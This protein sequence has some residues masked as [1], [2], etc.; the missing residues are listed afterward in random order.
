MRI[1]H[2]SDWHI[3]KRL[4]G[5][6]RLA[7]QADALDEIAALCAKEQIDVVLVAGDV[8]DTYLPSAEAEDL[9]YEKIKKIAGDTRAVVV[10]SGNHDD[11]VRLSAATPLCEPQGIY[12]YGNYGY[13]PKRGGNRPV[14]IADSGPNHIVLEKGGDKIF[15]NILPY[16]N[17]TRL[18]ED[19]NPDETFL[20]KMSRWMQSGQAKNTDGLPSVFLSHLFVAG[21]QVSE[22]ERDIDLGGARAVP[23]SL[24]PKAD[25][26]ALGH[27]HKCQ[28]FKGNVCY[29]GAILQYAFDE[30]GAAKSVFIFDLDR[31]GV[32]NMERRILQSGRSLVRLEANGIAA[33]EELLYRYEN[34][35]IELTIHLDE[36]M[37]SSQ[38]KQ[39]KD[40]N[41]GLVSIVPLIGSAL[42]GENAAARK[43][44]SPIELFCEFYKSRFSEQPSDEM[45]ELFVSAMEESNET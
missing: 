5:R 23:L 25:Y 24:L 7:E 32:H 41:E 19:K 30:A 29:S 13:V 28:Q 45:K 1:L 38:V 22:G 33:A 11:N 26:V 10:I 17:E 43:Q 3:G 31:T 27:L 35:F 14:R 42:P 9:F 20:D 8:F 36:P 16:P 2:T 18:K 12:I 40:A 37:A 6:E 15:V 34:S 4:L 44:L 21:G 39:L